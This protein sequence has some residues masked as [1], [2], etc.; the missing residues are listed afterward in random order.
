MFNSRYQILETIRRLDPQ[1][2]HQRIIF[3]S[4]CYDFPFDTTRSL[5]FALFRT[6]CVPSISALLDRTGEFRHR[7]QKRYDDTDIIVSELIEWG[8]DSDRG[9]RAL[10]RMNALHGRFNIAN[11]DFLYVLS[12]FIYEPIRWNERFGWRPLCDQERLGYFQFWREVG[13]R[14][15]IRDIPAEYETFERFNREYERQHYRFTETNQ[16]VGAAT[17]DLFVSWFPRVLSPLVRSAIYALLDEPLIEAFGF[18]R[19][20]RVMRRLIPA[21]LRLRARAVR[22]LPPRRRPRLRTAMTH[23]AYPAGYEIERLG[24]PETV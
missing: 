20:S 11:D 16:R 23:R 21:A 13:R 17:R 3:L 6:F 2:D 4:T 8:Y 22:F 12:T 24:P 18:P 5:E 19:P 14:M 15:S 7:A 10:E 9:R 1:A